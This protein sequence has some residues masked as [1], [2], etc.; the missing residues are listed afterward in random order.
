FSVHM[1]WADNTALA[2]AE[3]AA[4][5]A[6]R[7]DGADPWA[8]QAL[9]SVYMLARRFEDSRAAYELALKLNPNFAMAQGYYGLSLSYDGRWRE[10]DEA[11]QRA[12]R[13]SPRDP[14]SAVYYGIA[15]YAQFVGRN[16]R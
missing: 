8:H 16:Y 7:A 1:G 5:A 14:F 10:A 12:I 11:A 2:P 4:K 13:L 9:G 3:R 6:I 15:S